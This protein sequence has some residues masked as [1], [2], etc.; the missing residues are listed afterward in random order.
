MAFSPLNEEE[1]TTKQIR[2]LVIY[3]YLI[4]FKENQI[5]DYFDIVRNRI[6]VNQEKVS[7]TISYYL[8]YL[9]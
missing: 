5:K 9:L 1:S 6:Y 2:F 4:T 7:Q 8:T 3:G